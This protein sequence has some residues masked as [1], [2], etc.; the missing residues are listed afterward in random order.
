MGV[1]DS[2]GGASDDRDYARSERAWR[3]QQREEQATRY[4]VGLDLG[5]R[6]DYT[7]LAILEAS[8]KD[9]ILTLRRLERVRGKP[10]PVIATMV[11]D[12]MAALP[13]DSQLLVDTTGV[14]RPICDQLT[15][16]GVAHHRISIH[17]GAAV[18][19]LDDGTTSVPK[20]DL[21]AAL[22]VRFEQNTLLIPRFMRHTGTLEREARAFQM[23]LSASGH[24]TYNAR[25][26]EHDDLLLAVAMPVWWHREHGH[27]AGVWV[28]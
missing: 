9:D 13:P 10:Y 18:N 5:Q 14:G 23:K 16:L 27:R 25:S 11:R 28:L 7:A 26:G 20:R 19:T 24:D 1:L 21:V 12:T 17:G 15:A 3:E 8:S 4:V 6:D 2:W 22:V